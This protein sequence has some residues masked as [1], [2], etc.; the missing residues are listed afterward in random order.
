MRQRRALQG[1]GVAV[2][3]LALACAPMATASASG[4]KTKHSKHHSTTKKGENPGSALCTSLKSEQS[5]SNKLG[6]AVSAAFES[7]DFPTAKKD[8][9]N[10]LNLGLKE[11]GPALQALH[12]APANVQSAMRA[13]FKFEGNLKSAVENASSMTSLEASFESLGKNPQLQASSQTVT[14]YVTAQCG[15]LITTTT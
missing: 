6:E 8:M 14:N 2:I 12:S 1:F 5:N 7:G 3:G 10:A 13:L 11:V 4:H 15:S 9:I